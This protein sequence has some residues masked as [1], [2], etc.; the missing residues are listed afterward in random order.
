M[1]VGSMPIHAGKQ[2]YRFL[3]GACSASGVS[4]TEVGLDAAIA[5]VAASIV[6]DDPARAVMS[7]ILSDL[8]KTGFDRTGVAA[9]FSGMK[10][11]ESWRVG[12]F[13][14]GRYLTAHRACSFP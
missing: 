14:A 4:W 9:S 6:S 8:A 1:N 5:E 13:L 10:R 7:P 12:E 3:R 11:L 2:V